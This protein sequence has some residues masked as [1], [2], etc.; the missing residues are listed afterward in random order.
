[1]IIFLW[2]HSNHSPITT[3]IDSHLL[4]SSNGNLIILDI[5][6]FVHSTDSD[7]LWFLLNLF[8][9]SSGLLLEKSQDE[10]IFPQLH[11][12]E[13]FL[14]LFHHEMGTLKS[15]I[16]FPSLLFYSSS[17]ISIKDSKKLLET[18][19]KPENGFS[20]E[21]SQKNSLKGILDSIFHS[22]EFLSPETLI[23]DP[24]Q[25]FSS[26]NFI[27]RFVSFHSLPFGCLRLTG[28]LLTMIFHSFLEDGVGYQRFS[29]DIREQLVEEYLSSFEN[30][31]YDLFISQLKSSSSSSTLNEPTP[32]LLPLLK[33]FK[34][35]AIRSHSNSIALWDQHSIGSR[36][37]LQSKIEDDIQEFR[38]RI[39]QQVSQNCHQLLT[40]LKKNS[41]MTTPGAGAATLTLGESANSYNE[42]LALKN[43][44]EKLVT[45]YST[46]TQQYV[47]GA[48]ATAV[49]P[50]DS[51]GKQ[52]AQGGS[53]RVF[54]EE[55]N[56]LRSEILRAYLI[57]R[58]QSSLEMGGQWLTSFNDLLTAT[59]QKKDSLK[60]Q[61][62]SLQVPSSLS[63]L[64]LLTLLIA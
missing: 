51:Q 19:L 20:E 45:S 2:I 55:M 25:L 23:Q 62:Q 1:M 42:F 30:L 24:F 50:P 18:F 41:T 34:K 15:A 39:H 4:P 21:I 8:S 59:S 36:K 22:K 27:K 31:S 60:S 53:E 17:P 49:T 57:Q 38:E 46:S 35:D 47:T 5:S 52:V 14:S 54:S 61:L 6:Q 13:K 26:P 16:S 58:L 64:S 40:D 44:I 63:S 3:G 29:S 56:A 7:S 9:L 12:L 48:T 11:F 32:A 10:T 28:S 33:S 43:A 37:K